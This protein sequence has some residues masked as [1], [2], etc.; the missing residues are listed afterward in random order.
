MP[1]PSSPEATA[2]EVAY[3]DQV[4]ALFKVLVANLVE[5]PVSPRGRSAVCRQVR[6]RSRA[7]EA[8]K[9]ISTQRRRTCVARKKTLHH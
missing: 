9:G 7:C 2:I 4:K 1:D 5:E 8:G 6:G 3:E